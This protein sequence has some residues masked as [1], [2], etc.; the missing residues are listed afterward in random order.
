MRHTCAWMS[1]CAW[2]ADSSGA[3]LQPA[4]NNPADMSARAPKILAERRFL[5]F[6]PY[7]AP[8]GRNSFDPPFFTHFGALSMRLEV[9][10]G[11]DQRIRNRNTGSAS[12]SGPNRTKL[13]SWAARRS[14]SLAPDIGLYLPSSDVSRSRRNWRNPL[15]SDLRQTC[16]LGSPSTRRVKPLSSTSIR[17]GVVGQRSGRME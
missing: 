4:T 3:G 5:T 17:M 7:N 8:I 15:S 12:D 14:G 9:I 2:V 13:N 16:A 6:P 10:S 11:T 1:A